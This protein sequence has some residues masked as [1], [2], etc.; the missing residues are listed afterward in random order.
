MESRGR[1]GYQTF[2]H[3]LS[4]VLHAPNFGCPF[5]L[6]TNVFD[7]GLGAVLLQ[8]KGEEEHL[9]MYIS[10]K[11]ADLAESGTQ[12]SRRKLWPSGGQSWSWGNTPAVDVPGKGH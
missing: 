5:I 2:K 6:Q 4:P 7:T 3:A 11:L 9:V 12:P 10:Q 8:M 1:R